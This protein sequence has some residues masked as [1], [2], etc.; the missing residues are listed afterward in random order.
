MV[1]VRV[2]N[3]LARKDKAFRVIDTHGGIG[4]YD[5]AGIEAGKTG[6]WLQGIGRLLDG[7]T[8]DHI[9]VR[10]DPTVVRYLEI[11]RAFNPVHP[12]SLDH[13]S[14]L[15]CYPGSPALARHLLRPQDTLLVNELHPEDATLLKAH[16]ARDRQTTV[17]NL[18]GWV[19][20]KSALPPKERRG[21][22]LIDPPFELAGEFDRMA[23]ALTE[24]VRRFATGVFVLWYPIKD[25]AAVARFKRH[26]AGLRLGDTIAVELRT[27]ATGGSSRSDA[28]GL[29][30]T[31]LVIH[32]PPFGLAEWLSGLMPALCRILARDAGA[33]WSVEALGA[34]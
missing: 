17:L 5:L 11:I 30:G 9:A 18:D 6:E 21:V 8:A 24:G 22:I 31:G 26:V 33:S 12:A 23:K 3:Y 4:E 1:L 29:S 2:I 10:H 25:A 32:N 14:D 34:D 20:V 13:A 28:G 27:S 15:A 19:V 16:F 7:D